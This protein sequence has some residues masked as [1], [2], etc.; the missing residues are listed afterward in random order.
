MGTPKLM[1]IFLRTF[2]SIN[3]PLIFVL[4]DV[5]IA[6]NYTKEIHSH[7]SVYRQNLHSDKVIVR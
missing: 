2:N 5:S 3:D 4:V 1:A 6:Q 7:I